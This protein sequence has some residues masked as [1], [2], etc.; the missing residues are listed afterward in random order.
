MNSD[1]K[2]CPRKLDYPSQFFRSTNQ[3][4]RSFCRETV[5][6]HNR[7]CEKL[8]VLLL[9]KNT[10]EHRQQTTNKLLLKISLLSRYISAANE[11]NFHRHKSTIELEKMRLGL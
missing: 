5:E 8:L 3:E 11:E 1:K 2:P 6:E 9:E 7:C 4:Y 10:S